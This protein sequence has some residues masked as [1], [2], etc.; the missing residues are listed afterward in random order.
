M[1]WPAWGEDQDIRFRHHLG[2]TSAQPNVL[3]KR[4][5]HRLAR[6]GH[7]DGRR[8]YTGEP[9]VGTEPS[10]RAVDDRA[11]RVGR[12]RDG[13]GRQK[14]ARPRG[15]NGLDRLLE[16]SRDLRSLQRRQHG[17]SQIGSHLRA[18]SEV[19]TTQILYTND[20]H[21]ER[22]RDEPEPCHARPDSDRCR[23]RVCQQPQRRL[24][25]SG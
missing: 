22:N 10:S 17:R 2:T 19:G 6:S 5:E 14:G 13:D 18:T 20:C 24:A 16:H 8:V 9:R 23:G 3:G 25:W 4:P 12:E 15:R 1:Q 21:C 7:P 11:G